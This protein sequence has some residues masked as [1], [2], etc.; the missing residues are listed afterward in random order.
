MVIQELKERP[1]MVSL[2]IVSRESLRAAILRR[3]QLSLLDGLKKLLAFAF[4]DLG[5]DQER[6]K[7]HVHAQELPGRTALTTCAILWRN[8]PH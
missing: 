7:T 6:L 3:F 2:G 4:A 5:G 8:L 1:G